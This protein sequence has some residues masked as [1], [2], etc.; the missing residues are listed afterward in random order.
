MKRSGLKGKYYGTPVY[1]RFERNKGSISVVYSYRDGD[2][3]IYKH[4]HRIV[5]K[6]MRKIINEFSLEALTDDHVAH[7]EEI[8]DEQ[9]KEFFSHFFTLDAAFCK[10][11]T[12]RR[13]LAKEG[14]K[15]RKELK[16]IS[17]GA[18]LAADYALLFPSDDTRSKETIKDDMRVLCILLEHEGTTPWREVTP[19]KCIDWL[20]KESVHNQQ[21]VK[22]IMQSF[23]NTL[24][25]IRAVD[26][27]LKW[28]EYDP[29]EGK[30]HRHSRSYSIRTHIMPTM[31]TYDQCRT[32]FPHFNE[33][34]ELHP[35]AVDIAI[36]LMATLGLDENTICGLN[37]E[38]FYFLTDFPSRMCVNIQREYMKSSGKHC[39]EV[40]ISDE[41]K[42]RELPLSTYVMFCITAFI[43]DTKREWGVK[44]GSEP[45]RKVRSEDETEEETEVVTKKVYHPLIHHA[46]NSMRRMDPKVLKKL[47]QKKV[48][49][50]GFTDYVDEEKAK[51][52]SASTLLSNTAIR[53]MKNS[54]FEDEELR[55]MQGIQPLSVS[56]KHY[57]DFYNESEQNAM[58]AMQDRWLNKVVSIPKQILPVK[59]TAIGKLD[60]LRGDNPQNH[61]VAQIIIKIPAD[62]DVKGDMEI[63]LSAMYG[64]KSTINFKEEFS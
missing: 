1:M 16:N 50:L 25:D 23:L 18:M 3:I 10:D 22:R 57:E 19:R 35:K 39:K 53:E 36:V 40:A 60:I 44:P 63:Y 14:E 58:G 32:L 33:K 48:D 59:K 9:L 27:Y 38:D 42:L 62:P 64:F 45:K 61:T 37:C 26:D 29:R 11:E 46:T 12:T 5:T 30:S 7:L 24:I 43:K 55:F 28:D 34:E 6:T 51:I 54:G 31:L 47:V 4:P 2:K 8:C 56:A 15:R 49:A 17:L 21:S 41:H 52:V 20:S 13:N